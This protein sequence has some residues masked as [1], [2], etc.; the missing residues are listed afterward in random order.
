[1]NVLH[2][3]HRIPYPPDK[4][5]KIRSF[6]QWQY[7]AERHDVWCAFFVDDPKEM[8]HV[9]TIRRRCRGVIAIPLHRVR[10]TLRGV[11]RLAA[12]GSLTEG[13]YADR[14]MFQ[15]LGAWGRAVAFDAALV[16]SSSMAPY[17]RALGARR[18]VLDFCDWDSLKWRSY[19][20]RRRGVIRRLFAL[21]ARR[22]AAA[23]R[24]WIREYDACTVVTQA[25]ADALDDRELRRRVHV[26]GNGVTAGERPVASAK[27]AAHRVGF[28]GQM[29]YWP[30][31]DA[32][33][34]FADNVW[35]QVR[36]EVPDATFDIIGRSPTPAVRALARRDGIRVTG[37]V[38]DAR[39]HLQGCAVS[40]AP[41]RVGR[42]VQNKVL[43]AMAAAR[44][45]VLSSTAAAGIHAT[46]GRHF[47]IADSARVMTRDLV[48]LL[49]DPSRRATIG[50]AARTHITRRHTWSQELAKLESLL[51]AP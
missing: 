45:V 29:D 22:L 1:M 36:R 31:V 49:K 41:L 14:R 39:H 6:H 9:D 3:A 38:P 10:A 27:G 51:I 44:P 20:G 12:G 15:A 33:Q 23:E 11:T 4:G 5:D 16:F 50:D 26:V 7:L 34:W 30:N 19:A 48:T 24:R 37:A 8:S 2:L 47:L 35:P 17:R 28:V 40:V 21:E 42:G 46:P 43:E 32:V 25:E 13:Y 18:A